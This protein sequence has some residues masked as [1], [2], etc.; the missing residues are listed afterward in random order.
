MNST[1]SI[2]AS[3]GI[4]LLIIVLFYVLYVIGLI[5][6]FRKMGEPGWKAIIPIYN[7][8]TVYKR[9]WSTGMFCISLGIT[10]VAAVINAMSQAGAISTVLAVIYLI[11]SLLSLVFYIISKYKLSKAF[12]GGIGMALVLIILPSIGTIILGFS[13]F[14]YIKD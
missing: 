8:Y 11:F 2:M 1:T 5:K 6:M 12:D 10:V 4:F 7:E 9:V 3:I 14:R 13:G